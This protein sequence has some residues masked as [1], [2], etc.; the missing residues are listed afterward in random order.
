MRMENFVKNI[1]QDIEV[2]IKRIEQQDI[3]ILDKIK[4]IVG[5]IQTSLARL[6][7]AVA[8]YQ[9]INPEEEILFFKVRK[10]QISG[11]LIFYIR[12]Y[13]IEKNRIGKS[14]SV[15]YKYLKEAY[16]TEKF[17]KLK[18]ITMERISGDVK[19]GFEDWFHNEEKSGSVVLDLHVHDLD[20]LRYMLGEPDSFQVK[21]SRFESGMINHIITE[22]E[23]GDVFATAEGIWDE[24]SA[25]KFHAA[26]R[27]H[28]EDATIEF[29]GAQSP[30]LTVYKK[31]GTVE[32]PELKAEYEGESDVAGINVSNLGP[33][34][35]EIKYFQE[36]VREDKPVEVAPLIEGVR[37]VQLG[38]KEWN[39]AKEYVNT[40]ENK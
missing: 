40:H 37:S 24:S 1:K 6:K 36:C 25:M 33:Y 31:D 26:F 38:I 14:P 35:T 22:Y 27:A 34:Y 32:T 17:G 20:F 18:S 11:L 5:F 30:S 23:F 15:Q 21:A 39:A 29:N 12:L 28:F 16:D 7:A 9:F 10:P 2:K 13:Q 19:W 8:D 4:Q 3:D